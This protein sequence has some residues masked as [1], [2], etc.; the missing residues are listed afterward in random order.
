MSNPLSAN[1]IN[2][3]AYEEARALVVQQFFTASEHPDVVA[4]R[5]RIVELGT[6]VVLL[7]PAG[8]QRSVALTDLESVQMRANRGIFEPALKQHKSYTRPGGE[9]V[10]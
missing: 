10:S 2:D 8:R 3:E 9:R 7:V 4:L 5:D 6:A 1:G